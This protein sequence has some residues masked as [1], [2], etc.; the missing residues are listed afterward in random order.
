MQEN[1]MTTVRGYVPQN[2]GS[3][4]PLPHQQPTEPQPQLSGSD[5]LK[6]LWQQLDPAAVALLASFVLG[7][8]Y[9][10]FA[11]ISFWWLTKIVIHL[12]LIWLTVVINGAALFSGRRDWALYSLIGYGLSLLLF[13]NYFYL[14]LPSL[15]L[16]LYAWSKSNE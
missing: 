5:R 3:M 10:L 6:A 1:Q 15:V 8:A 14:L 11:T 7:I 16:C 12:V 4:R 2:T 9:A 13:L